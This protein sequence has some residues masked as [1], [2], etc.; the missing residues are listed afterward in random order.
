VLVYLVPI[1]AADH[2]CIRGVLATQGIQNC[3]TLSTRLSA[4]DAESAERSVC[5][6]LEAGGFLPSV[7]GKSLVMGYSR[8]PSLLT[9]AYLVVGVIIAAGHHYLQHVDHIKQ[10]AEAALAVLAWPLVLLGVSM[11]F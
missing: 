10:V 2:H 4:D 11:R 7:W 6:G 9:I 8:G 3:G 1:E 5:L